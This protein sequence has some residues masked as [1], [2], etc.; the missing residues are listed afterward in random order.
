[1][2]Y[3]FGSMRTEPI[4]AAIG[5]LQFEVVKFRL[6]S[7]YNVKTDLTILPFSIA[8]R[9]DADRAVLAA[10]SFPSNARLI[11]DWDGAPVV[12]FESEWSIRL[13]QEWNP[14]LRFEE[15]ASATTPAGS[16]R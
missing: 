4:L 12:L 13:A 5:A 6:E 7:E 15:F 16:A 14:T 2:F 3:P 11:E 9:V 8:R 10:A 1:M